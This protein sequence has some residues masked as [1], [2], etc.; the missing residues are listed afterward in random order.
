MTQGMENAR[1][2]VWIDT[3]T[4]SYIT[5]ITNKNL[6]HSTRATAQY[7]TIIKMGK[8]FEKEKNICITEPHCYTSE[9]NNIVNQLY[10]IIKSKHFL[11]KD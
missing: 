1:L 10:S 11:K 8:E 5:Q 2:E 6:L 3:Y 9:T 7:P 4:L